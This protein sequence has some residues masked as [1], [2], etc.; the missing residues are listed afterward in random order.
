MSNEIQIGHYHPGDETQIIN[1]LT[2]VFD[3][4]PNFEIECT[5]KEYWQWKY[6]DKPGKSSLIIVAKV[7]ERIVGCGHTIYR[8]TLVGNNSLVEAFGAD[9]AV[10]KQYRGKRIS[11]KMSDYKYSLNENRVANFTT[12]ASN[13]ERV[14]TRSIRQGR[15]LFPKRI[16]QYIRLRDP[17]AFFKHENPETS[18][19]KK[20]GYRILSRLNKV[21]SFF[22]NSKIIGSDYLIKSTDF[23]DDRVNTFWNNVKEEFNFIVERNKD[24]LNWRYCDPRGGHFEVFLAEDMYDQILGYVVLKVRR[25]YSTF[26]EGYIVDILTLKERKDVLTNLL[27]FAVEYFDENGVNMS[28]VWCVEGNRIESLLRMNGFVNSRSGP[29]IYF[30]LLDVGDEWVKFMA[31]NSSGVHYHLGDTD[32]M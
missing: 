29:L 16:Y 2:N 4:W 26:P 19:A 6:H 10:D 31:S 9:L 5:P 1:L 12:S 15:S 14:T 8:N 20:I 32:W 23:F 24:I 30:R 18:M 13:I 28:R 7:N 22:V 17:T 25:S 11:S 27:S 21:N 3:G